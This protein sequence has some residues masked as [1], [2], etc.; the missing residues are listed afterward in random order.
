[1]ANSAIGFILVTAAD[2]VQV[3][4]RQQD[5]HVNPFGGSNA[6]TQPANPEGVIPFV[7]APGTKKVIVGQLLY[8]VEHNVLIRIRLIRHK[9]KTEEPF[10]GSRFISDFRAWTKL[11]PFNLSQSPQS[12]QRKIK[13]TL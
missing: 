1:M 11:G 3:S 12:T 13:K 9:Q 4:G 5:I 6:F 10:R 2:I 8:S 7:A